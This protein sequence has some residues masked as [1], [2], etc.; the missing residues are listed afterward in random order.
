MQ[1]FMAMLAALVLFLPIAV[2]AQD[3]GQPAFEEG[4]HYQVLSQPV[5]TRDQS[6]IEVVELFW[7]G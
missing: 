3:A 6:K 7:Y 2:Q 5:R 4:K 1:K